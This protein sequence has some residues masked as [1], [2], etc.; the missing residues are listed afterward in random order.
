MGRSAFLVILGMTLMAMVVAS[1]QAK[2]RLWMNAPRSVAIGRMV[3]VT[4][5]TGET[6]SGLR[7]VVVAPRVSVMDVVAATTQSGGATSPSDVEM[8]RDGFAVLMRRTGASTW[9]ARMRFARAGSWRLVIPNWSLQGYAMPL[10]LVK[11]I[12]VTP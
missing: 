5:R 9:K 12:H 10:P 7:L 11:T 4:V 8:P 1:A 6:L 2:G 3:T